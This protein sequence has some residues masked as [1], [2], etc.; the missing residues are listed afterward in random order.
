MTGIATE[1]ERFSGSPAYEM[2][3]HRILFE[4]DRIGNGWWDDDPTGMR[5]WPPQLLRK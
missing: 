2:E 4:Y 5:S 3:T 1:Q